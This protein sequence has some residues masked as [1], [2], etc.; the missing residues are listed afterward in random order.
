MRL[1]PFM[2]LI[3]IFTPFNVSAN[4]TS[5]KSK[6]SEYR[7]KLKIPPLLNE[8]KFVIYYVFDRP[9]NSVLKETV[10]KQFQKIGTVYP[11][12]DSKLSEK[13]KQDKFRTGGMIIEIYATQIAE[14]TITPTSN[15]QMLPVF[16]VSMK[17]IGGGKIIKN[18]SLLPVT[19]WEK[20]QFIGVTKEKQEFI[21]KAVKVMDDMLELF[22]QEYQEA[23]PKVDE[24]KPQLFFFD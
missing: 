23:N 21:G 17:V 13:E 11:S 22:T 4:D 18:G 20:E 24:K 8:D 2:I 14:E 15:Y 9:L 12:G 10:T 5:D 19:F 16:K 6:E 1:F 7:T 3:S